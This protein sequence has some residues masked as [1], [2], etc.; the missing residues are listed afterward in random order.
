MVYRSSQ[1]ISSRDSDG[2]NRI[3]GISVYA[4]LI[5]ARFSAG[6]AVD[7]GLDLALAL[8]RRTL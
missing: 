7:L 3:E 4:S 8:L 5:Y 6:S 1:L 2:T